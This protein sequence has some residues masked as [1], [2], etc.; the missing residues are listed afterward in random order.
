[1][2][3]SAPKNQPRDFSAIRVSLAS[4]NQI[5]HWS[6]G[7][8]TKP[9][10]INYR[11]QKPEKDGLFDERIFGPTKDWE[12]Y[13]GKYKKIRY[14]GIVCDKCGVE[15]TRSA[16]RR[17]RMA[18]IKLAA[19]VVHIWYLRGTFSRLGLLLGMSIKYLE[20][21]VYFANFVITNVDD[22]KREQM[23]QQLGT[24]YEKA[25]AEHD[26]AHQQAFKEIN[27]SKAEPA[28]ITAERER[29]I[30]EH[31]AEL[32]VLESG[33]TLALDELAHL[34]RM[35]I[36]SEAKFREF[37]EKYAGV[38][39]AGVGAEAILE[40]IEQL[41]LNQ[42]AAELEAEAKETT[43]QRRRKALKRLNLVE[44][45]RKAELNPAWMIVTNLPVIPPDLRP[46]VQLDGGRF[47]ASD[48][49]DLYRRVINRNN[50]L[51]KL[52]KLRAPEVI[53]RNEKRMLQEA[54]DALIDNSARRG[55]AVSSVG[56][57][58]RLKSLSD[59]L[60][61]KQGR[62]RQNLLGKRVDYSGRSVI[63]GGANM[64]LDECGLPKRMALEL[65]K[66]FV[67]GKLLAGGFSHNV[68]S[69]SKT[70]DRALQ[71]A[72]EPAV[73][74][75]LDEVTKRHYVLLNRAPTLHRLG[76]QA[77]RPI[78]IEGKAI[79]I[80]PLVCTAFNAD[81]D[82]DQMAV[83][84]PLSI[85]AQEEARLLMSSKHNLLKP[86]AGEPVVAPS[87]EIVLGC[88][89]LTNVRAG[90]KGEGK[91]FASADE[92]VMAEQAGD[93]HIQAKVRVRL[94]GQ[95]LIETSVGRVIFN[96]IL[97]DAV[98]YRNEAMNKKALRALV[99]ECYRRCGND[100]TARV[101]DDLKNL[102]FKYA[103]ISGITISSSDLTIPKEKEKIIEGTR[104]KTADVAT[105]YQEGLITEQ[106]RY[107]KV[108]LLW[109]DATK[110]VEQAMLA[111]QD[112]HNPVY[113]TVISGAR[114]D[115]S[116]LNQM[117]GMKGV[118]VNPSGRMIDLPIISNYKEGL[119]AL[120]YFIST[121]GARKGLT[122]KGL[123]TP[124][125][126]YLT[127]RLVDVAQDTVITI[128][129]CKTKQ[130]LTFVTTEVAARG[131]QI[132]DRISGR[133]LLKDVKD[134]KGKVVCKKGTLLD[135]EILADL[136]AT[137]PTE[138][139]VRSVLT[140]AHDW[141]VCQC[142]YGLDL[143]LGR[144]VNIG[145]AVGVI[146]A[147]SIGEPGTQ[148]TM[149]TFHTGGVAAEDITQGLPRVEELFEARP[150]KGQAVLSE[151]SGVVTI[152]ESEDKRNITVA[153]GKASTKK[154]TLPEGY[155]AAVKTGAKVAEG[156]VLAKHPESK[157][158]DLTAPADGTIQ[159]R[160]DGLDLLSYSG[161]V[162]EYSSQTFVP[163]MPGIESGKEVE[164][165]TQLTEGTLNLHDLLRISG[166]EATWRYIISEVQDIYA[167]QAQYIS[168]KH[169]EIVVK[170]MLS[171]V[172]VT[173]SGD[174]N[175]IPSEV[176]SEEK[177]ATANELAKAAGKEQAEVEPMVLGITKA[178]LLTDSF[179]S[180]ASFQET[181]RILIDA[182]LTSQTD[183]L[184]GL[185]E[186]V[187]IGKLIPAGTGMSDDYLYTKVPK[188]VA[189]ADPHRA[190][191]HVG[192]PEGVL[193][194]PGSDRDR[195]R[196]QPPALAPEAVAESPEVPGSVSSS[197]T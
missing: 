20:K 32:E 25:K 166:S 30:T 69:A 42:L 82:G 109:R 116:Q 148:L 36:I 143:A 66:P 97:P 172:R 74:D 176:V 15:V 127:R 28:E 60:K 76:I 194:Y 21:V 37:S 175:L 81:F 4:S 23:K 44:G 99:S 89:Y 167:S 59:M 106:E 192:L 154:I 3:M 100:E 129:D 180:A 11:T 156:D 161:E 196:P 47:A 113:Q 85:K 55:R 138:V 83:H 163:L 124:D 49:N 188:E 193:S 103:T 6:H 78:L 170:Q 18:H 91:V 80:H 162:K 9:E 155:K 112:P 17:E 56:N 189:D 50:R 39:T 125:A 136:L 183:T 182:A 128:A 46:M 64:K 77:F 132:G 34:E 178:S 130:G 10:T 120:E 123:R 58:R 150:P 2:S 63:V 157:K 68:K 95:G 141:G 115:V 88:F 197:H 62:F 14:K 87:L 164:A 98:D 38:F 90:S 5:E 169:I 131:E 139:T 48:L 142:C 40:I 71:G 160:K 51:K 19:P 133:V 22:E 43:G 86:A 135:R 79:K 108:V 70:I 16:V 165:G 174:T 190:L 7:E 187:I 13:C 191:A 146:A 67:I 119:K 1:M 104:K 24:D 179:L 94:P 149:R 147:Q 35:E 118:V 153:A 33:Y 27:S 84:V 159:V 168:D 61:G 122:D 57:R 73:W 195:D 181:T 186:N 110:Q 41:D 114:G 65:F 171:K 185:K 92:A 29:V 177:V 137:K 12:C 158:K 75:M 26:A 54:V 134:A 53:Q 31:A 111:A 152:E 184:R 45:F 101:V 72:S 93:V 102:G 52:M 145:E 144:R 105:Q 126:G 173:E 121:H 107:N 96:E 8:V 140:C 117:A 151:V